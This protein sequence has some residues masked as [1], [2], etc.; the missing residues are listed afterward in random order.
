MWNGR[1]RRRRSHHRCQRNGWCC[2]IFHLFHFGNLISFHFVCVW[3]WEFGIRS[4][5]NHIISISLSC[6]SFISLGC[7][8]I[9]CSC[10][11]V[12]ATRPDH[13]YFVHLYVNIFYSTM[14]TMT[15]SATISRCSLFE[16]TP[17]FLWWFHLNFS[18]VCTWN[19]KPAR[20]SF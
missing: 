5:P 4:R 6:S 12:V 10:C 11:C 9:S 19:G 15:F 18:V 16:F 7:L 13:H 14:M 2:F 3:V 1:I 20:E 17:S 8:L